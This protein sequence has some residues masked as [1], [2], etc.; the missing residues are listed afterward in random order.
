MQGDFSHCSAAD[1]GP[2]PSLAATAQNNS[3]LVRHFL[4]ESSAKGVRV[5]GS[6]QEPYFGEYILQ[7]TTSSAN[8]PKLFKFLN[9]IRI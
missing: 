4:I 7:N 1:N 3:E 2:F 9:E 8:R 5:K 6:S